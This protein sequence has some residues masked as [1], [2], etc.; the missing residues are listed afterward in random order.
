MGS[1]PPGSV[2]RYAGRGADGG[3]NLVSPAQP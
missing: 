3:L 2:A 1:A